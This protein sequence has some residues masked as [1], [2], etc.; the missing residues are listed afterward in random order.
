MNMSP[1]LW[2]ELLGTR[3]SFPSLGSWKGVSQSCGVHFAPTN[4]EPAHPEKDRTTGGKR[5]GLGDTE[6][7]MWLSRYNHRSLRPIRLDICSWQGAD[8]Y[9]RPETGLFLE[10][11]GAGH[12]R[13]AQGGIRKLSSILHLSPASRV[14]LG[15]TL[16]PSRPHLPCQSNDNSYLAGQL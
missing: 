8:D 14:T 9:S 12:K 13:N 4:K 11:A 6:P 5:Q 7:W 15:K 16:S 2:V 10:G 3:P 1:G